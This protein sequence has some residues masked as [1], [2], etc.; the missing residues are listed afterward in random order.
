LPERIP[1]SVDN[2]LRAS[3]DGR[4]GHRDGDVTEIRGT[5]P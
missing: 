2:A 4:D 3:I 1:A 5:N